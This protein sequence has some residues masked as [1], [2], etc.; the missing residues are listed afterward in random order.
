[1]PSPGTENL[2]F[3]RHGATAVVTMNRPEAKNAL[4]LPMLVGMADAWE[5]I[6]N[7]D[8]IRCAVLTGA[9]GTFCSGMD[10]K[11]MAAPEAEAYRHRQEADPD[12]H[13]KALLRHYQLR[14]PLI[15]AVEGWAV[16]GGT[17]ILQATDVRVAGE[18]AKFGVFEARRGLFP[19][20][21]STV[22]LRRQIPFTV[23]MDLLLTAREVSAQEAKEI[24]LIGRVVP[25]GKALD[26]ALKIAE[27]IC[28]NGPLAVEAIKRSVRETE[29]IPEVEALKI[30]LE[31][32]WPIFATEDAKE[33]QKAFAEKRTPEYKRR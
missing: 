28:D 5:E 15:A 10:L 4:S 12:L 27:V 8:D 1:M 16:A 26:E 3:E 21:G 6:D 29:G 20:G 22:R 11:A 18:S 31:I 17:E 24:G 25:D 7:N 19:L 30:E 13:W 14:K 2:T 23:A 32:G 9:G 33:G